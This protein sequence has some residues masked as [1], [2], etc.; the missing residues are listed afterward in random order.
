MGPLTADEEC[1][2]VVDR[3]VL[4][5]DI[6]EFPLEYYEDPDDLLAYTPSVTAEYTFRNPADYAVRATL[7]FP[8]GNLPD[9]ADAFA[10]YDLQEGE[11]AKLALAQYGASIDGEPAQTVLR[12][13]LLYPYDK[14]FIEND[15]P[16]LRDGYADDPFY[17]PDL[18]VTNFTYEISGIPEGND[19][20]TI[21]FRWTPREDARILLMHQTGVKP[22]DDEGDHLVDTWVRN[23][24][25][26]EVY[27]FGNAPES[28]Q[29]GLFADGSCTTELDGR[30]TSVSIETTTFEEFALQEWDEGSSVLK[31][32]W[33]NAMVD[34]LNECEQGWGKGI[35]MRAQTNAH[36]GFDLSSM[37]LRW[38]EYEIELEPG[39]TLVNAVTAPIYP[40]IDA[41]YNPPVYGYSYLLSPAQTWAGFGE[42][43]VRVLTPYHMADGGA[44]GFEPLEGEQGYAFSVDGLP[45]GELEFA[46]SESADPQPPTLASKSGYLLMLAPI[47]LPL[48][49][50]GAIA[51]IVAGKLRKRRN[52]TGVAVR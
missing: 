23:G 4:T 26:V 9:Y 35:I 32:D 10:G 13:T 43:Q 17:S 7:V 18:P 21:G 45:E 14:F 22:I 1:P 37:L 12:H 16:K 41:D 25:V 11:R 15:L 40:S 29:A 20:A 34:D 6:Q 49:I 42:L 51:G 33:Y 24:Q 39:Q 8:F 52:G 2:I 44:S 3:E 46:L 47:V 36:D 27:V 31:H 48:F 28:L 50:V 30:I 19:A 5:F 38:Y